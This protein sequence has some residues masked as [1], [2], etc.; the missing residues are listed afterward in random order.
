[1]KNLFH[2]LAL[3]AIASIMTSCATIIGGASIGQKYKFLTIRMQRLN[4]MEII[5]GKLEKH[6]SR[7]K[8]QKLINFLLR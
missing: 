7:Q 6:H 8:D 2:F 5:R 1:M 4:I 3:L